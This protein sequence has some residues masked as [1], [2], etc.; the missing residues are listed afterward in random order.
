VA[1][2]NPLV[3][4]DDCSRPA[5]FVCPVLT[6]GPD[7]L[8]AALEAMVVGEFEPELWIPAAHP[9]ARDG[10]ISL[11]ELACLPVIRGPC[12]PA[13]GYGDQPEWAPAR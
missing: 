5:E 11:E 8:P 2:R 13:A 4:A 1:S 6:T 12:G 3:S 7:A 9:A 10:A